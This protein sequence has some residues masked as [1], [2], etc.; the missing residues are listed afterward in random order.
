MRLS[1]ETGKTDCHIIDFVDSTSRVPGIISVP[2]LF[3]LDADTEIKSEFWVLS[4]LNIDNTQ[5]AIED[6]SLET[7]ERRT[8]KAGFEISEVPEPTSV[9]YVDYD[10]P[11]VSWL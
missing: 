5:C 11:F 2:T 8:E 7:L 3:G 6:E 1:P 9:T 10:N 4:N